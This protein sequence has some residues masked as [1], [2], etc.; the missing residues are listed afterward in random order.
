MSLPL[1][2]K[3]VICECVSIHLFFFHIAHKKTFLEIWPR[4]KIF[5]FYACLRWKSWCICK[6]EMQWKQ[7]V[8]NSW[9]TWS[10][11]FK[12]PLKI[13]LHW[14]DKKL[15]QMKNLRSVWSD[16]DNNNTLKQTEMSYFSHV[17]KMVSP[18]FEVWLVLW[19]ETFIPAVSFQEVW[20]KKLCNIWMETWLLLG[21]VKNVLCRAGNHTQE[22]CHMHWQTHPRVEYISEAKTTGRQQKQDFQGGVKLL[23]KGTLWSCQ[24]RQLCLHSES[25]TY[26]C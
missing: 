3:R 19:M 10:M 1:L 25:T 7:T 23:F 6:N 26:I 5:F 21:V 12:Y 16:K 13:L 9:S 18:L 4:K 15:W 11:R 17:F 22:W 8:N 20:L 24:Q 2:V 14:R